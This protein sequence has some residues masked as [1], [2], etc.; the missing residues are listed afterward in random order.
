MTSRPNS[1][2]RVGIVAAS[3]LIGLVASGAFVWQGSRAAFTAQTGTSGNTWASGQVA[4]SDDD[5]GGARFTVSGMVPGVTVQKCVLVTYTGTVASTVKVYG[6]NYS[7]DLGQYLNFRI[8]EGT[9]GTFGTPD[10]SDGVFTATGGPTFDGTLSDGAGTGQF[11]ASNS[12]ATG[13]GTWTPSSN[14]TTRV[15][16]FTYSLQDNDLA[17]NKSCGIDLIWEARSN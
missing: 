16:R 17:Q 5:S 12:W 14:P 3:L 7:G 4:L 13:V 10:C 1:W 8:E 2:G 6:A 9:G 11:S 15:Y